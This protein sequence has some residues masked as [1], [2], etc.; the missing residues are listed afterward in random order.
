MCCS[1]KVVSKPIPSHENATLLQTKQNKTTRKQTKTRFQLFPQAIHLALR[2]LQAQSEHVSN[3]PE[4]HLLPDWRAEIIHA[5]KGEFDCFSS[6]RW[7]FFTPILGFQDYIGIAEAPSP[8]TPFT[9][10]ND[11]LCVQEMYRM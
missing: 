1:W 6:L 11:F 8:H 4:T 3:K 5:V 2:I 10:A 9:V 7:C